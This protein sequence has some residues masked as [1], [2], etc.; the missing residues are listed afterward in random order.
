MSRLPT[1]RRSY[2][3]HRLAQEIREERDAAVSMYG[4]ERVLKYYNDVL[5]GLE[6]L[7]AQ[8]YGLEMMTAMKR[9]AD[10]E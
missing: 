6:A 3:I 9:S 2:E 7:E 10:K 5:K 1:P 8:L 4:P